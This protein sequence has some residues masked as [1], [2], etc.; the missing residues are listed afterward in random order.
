MMGLWFFP[1]MFF[2]RVWSQKQLFPEGKKN[3]PSMAKNASTA[4]LPIPCD[5]RA[6][7]AVRI[8]PAGRFWPM[9]LPW[10]PWATPDSRAASNVCDPGHSKG[11]QLVSRILHR[12]QYDVRAEEVGKRTKNDNE[13]CI[14]SFFR[15]PLFRR[16]KRSLIG[17]AL[18]I[19]WLFSLTSINQS[20]RVIHIF[21]TVFAESLS[22]DLIVITKE[23][24]T[25]GQ[26][27]RIGCARSPFHSLVFSR[28]P[29][30]MEVE[31][32]WYILQLSCWK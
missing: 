27:L 12:G 2:R 24:W 5:R 30:I 1:C 15:I 10:S 16:F 25:R 19:F 8:V 18:G 32:G 14:N 20:T 17:N 28:P 11:D 4:F 9:F 3:A 13:G 22:V 7:R 29:T 31:N 26:T 21:R 6:G 23:M